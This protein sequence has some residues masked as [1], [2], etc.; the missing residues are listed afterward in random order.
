MRSLAISVCL[1]ALF[2]SACGGG[3]GS[4]QPPASPIAVSIS[5]GS[6][7]MLVG[8]SSTFS[9]TVSGSTNQAVTFSVVG[10]D[11][12]GTITQAGVYTAPAVPGSFRVRATSMQDASKFAEANIQVRDYAGTTTATPNMSVFRDYHTASLLADG[13]VLL[14]GGL[15]TVGF[16][17]TVERYVEGSGFQITGSTIRPRMAHVAA[18]LPDGKVLISGG[19]NY[20]EVYK[21]SEIYDRTTGQF[22]AGPEMKYPRREHVATRMSDGRILITGGMQLLGS[23]YG[24]TMNTELYDPGTN[25]FVEL[26]RLNTGRYRHTATLLANGRVLIVGGRD[27]NCTINCE[28]HAL[29][30]AEIY[31]PASNL[32]SYTGEMSVGRFNHTATLLPNGKVLILGG[33]TTDEIPGGTDQVSTAEIYDPSTGLFTPAGNLVAGRSQHSAVM[34]NNGKILLAGGLAPSGLPTNTSEVFDPKSNSS[35]QGP[36]LNELR[37][38]NTATKLNSGEVLIAG[39]HTSGQAVNSAEIYR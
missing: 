21:D 16:T 7:S 8:T 6:T 19:T 1:S 9:A 11:A 37:A 31:D 13:S 10:G 27:N 15:D 28:Y 36:L 26:A 30:T 33:E 3:S 12:N 4:G 20:A 23:G 2:L 38:R 25:S 24:A 39:G 22:T 5:P 14:V 17:R 29:R 32:Y 35:A 18:L 34:L